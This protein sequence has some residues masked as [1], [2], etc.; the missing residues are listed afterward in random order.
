MS[1]KYEEV[2]NKLTEIEN[3]ISELKNNIESMIEYVQTERKRL[4][5]STDSEVN[6]NG[7]T[8]DE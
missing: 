7:E 1:D 4:L 3:H 5:R 6:N 2:D 8:N